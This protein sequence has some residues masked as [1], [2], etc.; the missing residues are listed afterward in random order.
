MELH[1]N[2]KMLRT[3]R[4]L[5]QR[6]LADALGY[7]RAAVTQI[8]KGDVDLPL[9]RL[10][11]IAEF[12]DVSVSELIGEDSSRKISLKDLVFLGKVRGDL[13]AEQQKFVE[14]VVDRE[15]RRNRRK[16]R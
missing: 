14:M 3:A 9:S 12:F 13:D 16:G 1:E 11:Q 6:E 7:S 4:D 5:T 10:K 2:I 15:I 8:E